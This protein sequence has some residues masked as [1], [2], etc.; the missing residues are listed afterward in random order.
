MIYDRGIKY[1]RMADECAIFDGRNSRIY[2]IQ[3]Y[4]K[5]ILMMKTKKIIGLLLTA[6]LLFTLCGTALASE[7]TEEAEEPTA[8]E[9][10]TGPGPVVMEMDADSIDLT[11][12][13]LN[14]LSDIV[15]NVGDCSYGADTA[16]KYDIHMGVEY[17]KDIV[18]AVLFNTDSIDFSTPGEYETTY[19]I[20]FNREPLLAYMN[21]N[22]IDAED[23]SGLTEATTDHVVCRVDTTTTIN[24]AESTDTGYETGY[25]TAA[26]KG[27]TFSYPAQYE[28]EE[29]DDVG[30][31]LMENDQTMVLFMSVDMSEAGEDLDDETVDTILE[32][33]VESAIESYDAYQNESIGDMIIDGCTAKEVTALVTAGS[34]FVNF[35]CIAIYD[36]DGQYIYEVQYASVDFEDGNISEYADIV[37]SITFGEESTIDEEETDSVGANENNDFLFENVA[38]G[39]DFSENQ[40]EIKAVPTEDGLIA[41]FITNDSDDII[42]EINVQINYKDENGTTIDL[43]SDLHDVV[44]PG[45]TVVSRMKAPDSYADYEIETEVDPDTHPYYKNHAEDVDIQSNIG[46]DCII[47][48]IT[49]NGDD[50]IRE[51]EYDVV[52]YKDDKIVTI[53]YPQDV[54]D[55]EPGKT[56]TEKE[57]TY[58][59]D[60]DDYEIYLNQAHTFDRD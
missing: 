20:F 44:L 58:G 14:T 39:K 38:G 11:E 52:L 37:D 60:F 21:E 34:S 24:A 17:D 42:Q 29:E 50:S 56:V 43:D 12:E 36:Q 8:A 10:A 41:V 27:M 35:N 9:I 5:D 54:Y 49:N 16:S 51:I 26:Y 3:F 15:S 53:M 13:Q 6:A 31:I 28:Y 46:E 22:G 30:M 25:K 55:V 23:Y 1:R 19:R 57:N 47:I 33:A 7:S 4:R 59:K 40:L 48:E 32:Y 2:L 18:N 45:S